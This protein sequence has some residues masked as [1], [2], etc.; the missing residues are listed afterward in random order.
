MR[1]T[2]DRVAPTRSAGGLGRSMP[3]S[4]AIIHLSKGLNRADQS[5][6]ALGASAYDFAEAL[7]AMA[8]LH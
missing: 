8:R 1:F 3:R 2:A 4:R 6:S 7:G 5:S